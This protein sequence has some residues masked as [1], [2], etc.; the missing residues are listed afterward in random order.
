MRPVASQTEHEEGR[1][2]NSLALFGRHA[3]FAQPGSA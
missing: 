1:P 3:S 2:L